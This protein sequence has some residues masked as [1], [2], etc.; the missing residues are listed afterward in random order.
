YVLG[1]VQTANPPTYA[2]AVYIALDNGDGTS[3]IVIDDAARMATSM[4]AGM[5]DTNASLRSAYQA[6]Q[7][8]TAP[9][10]IPR[11]CAGAL[12][13][14]YVFGD[15]V[16]L[17]KCDNGLSWASGTC[18]SGSQ[19]WSAV[20]GIYS[21]PNTYMRLTQ[22]GGVYLR[23]QLVNG[24]CAPLKPVLSETYVHLWTN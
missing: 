5:T 2:E 13:D 3:S 7:S 1:N 24:A 22:P 16:P 14:N 23:S 17:G 6:W 21:G 18:V 11:R 20:T 10:P 4:P 12:Y 19:P 9:K 15:P 8:G